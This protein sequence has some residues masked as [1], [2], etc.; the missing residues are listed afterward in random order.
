VILITVDTLR[1][2]H[3]GAYGYSEPTSP[4]I[5]AFAAGATLYE[6]AVAQAPHTL[7]SLLQIMTSRYRHGLEIAAAEV[8]LAEI[9]RRQGYQTAAVVDN[10]LLELSPT[11]RGLMNGFDTFYRNGILDPDAE[12]Q[13]WKTKTPADCITAQGI[14]WLRKRDPDRPFFL[15]LHFFDPHDPYLPPFADDLESLSRK[16]DSEF[17]GDIRNTLLFREPKSAAAQH[18]LERDRRHLVALYDAE[19]RY[20]DQSLGELFEFL[21]EADLYDDSMVILGA[22]HG[23]SFG[24]HGLWMHGNSLYAAEVHVPLVVKFPQQ[25]S[26]ARG[27]VPVQAIDIA[28]T[29]IDAIEI[30]TGGTVFDGISLRSRKSEPAFAFW[31]PWKLVQTQEWK[32]LQNGDKTEL[33][34]M[35]DRAEERD[36]SADEP[37]VVETLRAAATAKLASVGVAERDLEPLSSDAI[38]RLRALGYLPK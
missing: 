29:I 19:I 38:E 31:G 13:H 12:Q 37:S 26:A 34:H 3:L 21:R 33:F 25:T 2:D 20:L 32:L 35:S 11:A 24:E 10:A 28:P 4:A 5:D 6:Q 14:R 22:D 8:T 30:P 15:W 1:A 17:T 36:R 23:E 18:L 16:S 9:L 27:R 7:P